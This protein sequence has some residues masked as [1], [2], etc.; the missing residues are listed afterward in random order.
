MKAPERAFFIIVAFGILGFLIAMLFEVLYDN[1][2]FINSVLANASMLASFQI[3][4]II[5]ALI[6]GIV[7]AAFKT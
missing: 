5:L 4:T 1:G 2:Y 7:V 3:C 6:C